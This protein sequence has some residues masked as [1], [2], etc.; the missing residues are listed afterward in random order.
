MGLQSK[1]DLQTDRMRLTLQL[2]NGA[3]RAF[4]VTRRQWLGLLHAVTVLPQSASAEAPPLPRTK[5]A[6]TAKAL[7]PAPIPVEAIRLRQ[8]AEGVKL[9]FAAA[10]KGV[11]ISLQEPG[12]QQLQQMLLQQ[13]ER[14]GWD[15][16]AALA[17]LNAQG[18]ARA[19]MRKA[20]RTL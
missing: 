1:Y 12:L 3:L 8:L 14:A 13:A 19:A 15:V 10:D 18:L 6:L 5:K 2:A 16:S 20:S 11:A 17:R 9:V 4:W 7:I